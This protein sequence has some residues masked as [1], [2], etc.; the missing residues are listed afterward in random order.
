M[1]DTASLQASY[2]HKGINGPLGTK[3]TLRAS[4]ISQ[5][6]IVRE[7]LNDRYADAIICDCPH[8]YDGIEIQGVRNKFPEG[9]PRGTCIAIDA[10][11][12]QF[13]SVY[14]RHKGGDSECVGDMGNYALA[15]AYANELSRNYD[16]SISDFTTN[17]K[18]INKGSGIA[19]RTLIGAQ[20]SYACITTSTTTLD[21][22][23]SSGMSAKQSLRESASEMR[24]AAKRLLARAD[25]I[26]AAANQF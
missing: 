1:N 8:E 20:A 14:V 18:E 23:L 21:V 5:P 13:Y 16:W 7:S 11:N 12:P 17:S 2:F 15:L 19:V 22:R 3:V 9:D 25:L 26:E 6:F 24:T 4:S 10:E